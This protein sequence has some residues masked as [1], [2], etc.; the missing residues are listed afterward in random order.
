MKAKNM[1]KKAPGSSKDDPFPFSTA[2][3]KRITLAFASCHK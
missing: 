2:D 1:E 3:V